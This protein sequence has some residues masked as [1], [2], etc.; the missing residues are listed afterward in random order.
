MPQLNNVK[1][2]IKKVYLDHEDD[3]Y[4]AGA[5]TK[6][7]IHLTIPLPGGQALYEIDITEQMYNSLEFASQLSAKSV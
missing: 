3:E 7:Q 4:R 1:L 5:R 6:A 2:D